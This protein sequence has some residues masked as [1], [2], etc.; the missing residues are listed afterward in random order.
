M[1][2]HKVEHKTIL[3]QVFTCTCEIS[4][5]EGIAKRLSP[6]P[7]RWAIRQLA[8]YLRRRESNSEDKASESNALSLAFRKY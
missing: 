5:A 6:M 3:K 8:K 4:A 2:E 1:N 7:Y